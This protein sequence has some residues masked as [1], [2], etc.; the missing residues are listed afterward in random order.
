MESE[1]DEAELEESG[2]AAAMPG[3]AANAAP[4][5]RAAARRMAVRPLLRISTTC[6][7][8][9]ATVSQRG[10]MLPCEPLSPA[11]YGSEQPM[12]SVEPPPPD[13]QD[14]ASLQRYQL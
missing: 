8:A 12:P 3:R 2:S 1:D 7:G 14:P 5:P 9:S 13:E 11:P 6:P 10:P 4:A